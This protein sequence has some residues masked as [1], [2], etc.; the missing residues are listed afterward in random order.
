[1][2]NIANDQ[3][4]KIKVFGVGGGG[5]N[6]VNRMA[7]SKLQ[8]VD[9]YVA[10][11]DQQALNVSPIENKIVLGE[12]ITKGQGAGAQP[13][14]GKEAAK[15]SE[16]EIRRAMEGADMVFVTAGLGGGTGTGAAPVFARIAKEIGALTVGVVTKPF[17]F[18]GPKRMQNA[19]AGL[20]ELK[21]YVDSLIVIS[22]NRILELIGRVPFLE[23]FKEADNVLRQSVQTITDLIM[24]PSHINLDFTDIKSV[25]KDR[26][27]ALIGIGMAQGEKKAIEAAQKALHSPLLEA[28]ITGAQ[29]AIINVT[30]GESITSYDAEEAVKYIRSEAGEDLDIIFGIAINDNLGDSMI[31]TVIATGFDDPEPEETL[32]RLELRKEKEE[33]SK[34][35]EDDKEA[36][37]FFINKE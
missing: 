13:N 2:S 35:I 8:G 12:S 6:A 27:S 3:I 16:D 18:E 29:S 1:M 21:Q 33:V 9:F 25:M 22:N 36:P 24:V 11:T 10:N 30:G 34:S 14:L 5:C 4:T 23:S 20:E 31:V 32:S 26:G 19:N 37:L 28:K 15:E 7:D 17:E